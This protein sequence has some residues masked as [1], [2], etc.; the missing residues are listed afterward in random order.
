MSVFRNGHTTQY[1]TEQFVG[2]TMGK[3]YLIVGGNAAGMSTATR[4]RRLDETAE[5]SVFESTANVSYASCGLP[6]HLSDTVPES[7]LAVM[8]VD[9][10]SAAFDLD[11]RT[12][13]TVTDIAPGAQRVTVEP[14][15]GDASQLAYDE[16]VLATGAE[17]LVPPMFDVEAIDGCHTLRTVEDAIG[18][19]AQVD[20]AERA[21]VIGG[22]YIGIEVAENLH[23][24]GHE[25]VVAELL[26]Q[27]MPNTLGAEMAALVE[28]HID[29][30]G[31]DLRLGTGVSEL[32][33]TENGTII[34]TM[35]DETQEFDLVVIA[36]GVRPRTELAEAAGL[37]CHDSGAIAVDSRLRTSEPS[38]HA[39]GDAVAVPSVFG[40]QAWIPLGGPANRQGRVA[41]NDIAGHDDELAPVLDTAIAK[42]FDLDVGTVGQTAAT[43]DEAGYEYEAVYTSEPNHAKYYPGA[44]DI[45]FKLLFD[46][47]DGTVFGAQAIGEAGVDK[48]I[49]V[50][51]TAI[52][53]GDTVFDIRDLDLAYAPPYSA[54]K[55]PVNVLGMIGANVVEG[56]AD[57][58]H[59]DEFTEIRERATVIDTRPAEM[60]EAQGSIPGDEHVPLGKLR[61]W[62]DNNDIDGEVVTYCKIGKSSYMATRVLREQGI[63]A[64]SLTGGYYRFRVANAMS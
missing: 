44:S 53:H 57:I 52:S 8:G 41:A 27:V 13:T 50:L 61:S 10:L 38:I 18:V 55:D 28:Q 47:A 19:R 64:R 5:I 49:D 14:D 51:A 3:Q 37:E 54:A 9:Q 2:S 11:I 34:A 17:P 40:E 20:D 59:L 21:L 23:E 60:R 62:I 29:S 1:L 31:V 25:V 48:R 58:I 6:Y 46:P 24:A 7:E 12:E 56:V 63:E 43:L 15:D 33:E 22:G 32:S 45:H 39:V 16:L 26:D 30:Q 36:T 35:D 42:V 4:L